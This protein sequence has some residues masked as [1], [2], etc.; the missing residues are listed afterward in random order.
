MIERRKMGKGDKPRPCRTSREEYNPRWLL[1]EKKI[2][3][4]EF[5]KRYKEL[6]Q[7]KLIYRK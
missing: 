3:F 6:E 4:D 1:I 2:A 5:E 7:R